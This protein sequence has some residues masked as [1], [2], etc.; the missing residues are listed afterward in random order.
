[1]EVDAHVAVAMEVP[2]VVELAREG[3]RAIEDARGAALWLFGEAPPEPLDDTY[4]GFVE[5]PAHCAVVVGTVDD[6][7]VGLLTVVAR[8]VP[9]GRAADVAEVYV[10]EGARG[11]GVGEVMMRVALDWAAAHEMVALTGRALPGDRAAKNFF[12]RHGLV[13]RS[14]EVYRSLDPS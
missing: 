12:E 5:D 2:A 3:R 10:I 8:A 6:T 7:I 14:I 9:G 11:V 4:R 1:M 13:A